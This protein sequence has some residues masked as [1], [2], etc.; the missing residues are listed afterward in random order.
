MSIKT[1]D[2]KKNFKVFFHVLNFK[3]SSPSSILLTLLA[4]HVIRG[5]Q[6]AI[7]SKR[8]LITLFLTIA[9]KTIGDPFASCKK[10]FDLQNSFIFADFFHFACSI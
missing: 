10:V 6:H 4:L 8:Y 2:G 1:A 5:F 3:F 9:L 7:C